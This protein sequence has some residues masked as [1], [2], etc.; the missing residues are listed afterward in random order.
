MK[1]RF[2]AVALLAIPLCQSSFAMP[3]DQLVDSIVD[4]DPSLRIK[5]AEYASAWHDAKS[6]NQLEDPEFSFDHYWGDPKI[7]DKYT[8]AVSQSFDWPSVYG[9]RS[10]YAHATRS[11]G[12]ASLRADRAA[13]VAEVR[14]LVTQWVY[15]NMMISHTQEAANLYGR[16]TAATAAAADSGAVTKLDLQ[17]AHLEEIS[18][19]RRVRQARTAREETYRQLVAANGGR[20][21]AIET[22]QKVQLPPIG[23]LKP[24]A[25]YREAA[26]SQPA[27]Q[28]KESLMQQ[29]RAALSVAKS[30]RL[31]K[32]ALGYAYNNEF[33][34][35]FHG[36]TGSITLPVYSRRSR[37][38]AAEEKCLAITDDV[39]SSKLM[40]DADIASAYRRAEELGE[41]MKRQSDGL[42]QYS[43]IPLLKE[44]IE[45]GL[46]TVTEYLHELD[47][48][49]TMRSELIESSFEFATALNTLRQL[50]GE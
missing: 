7:G 43:I 25:H 10:R 27:I 13:R 34:D 31:P 21:I 35:S 8:L 46:M 22:L 6:E 40:L 28:A 18:M 38:A 3:L 14:E 26:A 48:E 20:P 16:I 47:F 33:G 9:R 37:V 12:E 50:A 36:I 17:K 2:F 30:D 45:S 19:Q 15:N 32:F 24:L 44:S 11:A 1:L 29:S 41:E 5:A 42:A 39:E 23:H 49:L 4:S